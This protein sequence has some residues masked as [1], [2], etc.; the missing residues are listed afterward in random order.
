MMMPIMT[1]NNP[2]AL[3]KISTTKILTNKVEFCASERA[4]LLPTTP[5]EMLQITQHTVSM[6]PKLQLMMLALSVQ[7]LSEHVATQNAKERL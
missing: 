4:A 6:V 7:F 5:T 2:R 3:P 1:P